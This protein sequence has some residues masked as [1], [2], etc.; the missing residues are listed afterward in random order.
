MARISYEELDFTVYQ[1]SEE[2]LAEL[3]QERAR[4]LRYQ[5]EEELVPEMVTPPSRFKRASDIQEEEVTWL[6]DGRVP[7]GKLSLLA[8]IPGLG[9]SLVTVDMIAKQTRLEKAVL[10]IAPEDGA[11][12]TIVPR[13]KAAMAN[14]AM[15][16]MEKVFIIDCSCEALITFPEE[17]S[18]LEDAINE[19]EPSLVVI[20]PIMATLS[21]K[22]DTHKDHEVKRALAPIAS[23]AERK[24]IA[25]VGVMHF[26]KSQASTAL[27]RLSGSTAFGGQA[28]SVMA[29]VENPNDADRRVLVHIKSNLSKLASSMN[30]SLEPRGTSV[31]VRWEGISEHSRDELLSPNRVN[32]GRRSIDVVEVLKEDG[33]EMSIGQISNIL[34]PNSEEPDKDYDATRKTLQRRAD[35]GEINKTAR[36]MYEYKR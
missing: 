30:F 11:G 21:G 24:R 28:R 7:N 33:G 25:I 19:F 17:L 3:A 36:G 5:I 15:A 34:Y 26:N 31:Y 6:W 12:D 35:K 27:N 32:M 4:P 20:D 16:N 14:A 2:A 13:L 18:V 9:K 29:V 10:L 1:P 23:L 22:I 8:G